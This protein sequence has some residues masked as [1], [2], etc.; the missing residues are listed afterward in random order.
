MVKCPH[1]ESVPKSKIDLALHIRKSHDIDVLEACRQARIAYE[2]AEIFTDI[3][4]KYPH[5]TVEEAYGI[6]CM[7]KN[8]MTSQEE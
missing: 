2:T 3:H 6:Y 8:R 7:I 5:V 4:N 1:C